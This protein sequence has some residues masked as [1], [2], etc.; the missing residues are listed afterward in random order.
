MLTNYTK[1]AFRNIISDKIYTGIN[2]FGLGLG[3]ACSFII[4]LFVRH[5]LSYDE[6]YVNSERIYRLHYSRIYFNEGISIGPTTS[7][8]AG[9]LLKQDYSEIEEIARLSARPSSLTYN[10]LAFNEEDIHFADNE[11]FELFD[12]QWLVGDASQALTDP[13]SIVL[14]QSLAT[15]YFGSED[16]LGKTVV[17]DNSYLLTV[18][19][20]IEDLPDNTHLKFS[21]LI[22]FDLL[23]TIFL[24]ES[25]FNIDTWRFSGSFTYVML[26]QDQ[27]IENVR[28]QLPDFVSRHVPPI[29][30]SEAYLE[31]IPLT[32]VYMNTVDSSGS[33]QG[34]MVQVLSFSAIA[35]GILLIAIINYI[36]IANA[37]YLRRAREIGVRK[38]AGAD[39]S[40]IIKQ[41][42]IE[43]YVL[44]IMAMIVAVVTMEFLLPVI[45]SIIGIELLVG[46]LSDP[47]LLLSFIALSITL[48]LASGIYPVLV[49]SAY[50]PA[51]VLK[52][53]IIKG[54][55]GKRF[56]NILVIAQFSMAIILIVCISV[57][58]TQMQY[59][60][61]Y[62]LGFTKERVVNFTFPTSEAFD[63][64]S[65]WEAFKTQL[66][67]YPDIEQ[68]AFSRNSPTLIHGN[69]HDYF[70]ARDRPE[71]IELG[72]VGISPSYFDLYE[73][74]FLS[75][76][77][78]SN[79]FTSDKMRRFVS[80]ES[81][82]VKGNAILNESAAREFGWSPSEAIS[83]LLDVGSAGSGIQVQVVG[84]VANTTA[85][86]KDENASL[87]YWNPANYNSRFFDGLASVKIL[88]Y[89]ISQALDHIDATWGTFIPEVPINRWFLEDEIESLYLEEQQQIQLF[90]Y[91]ASIAVLLAC[92]GLFGLATYNTEQRRKEIGVRKV[93]GGS[94]WQI[95]LLLTNDFSKL[96]LTSNLIAWPI[97]F[98]A[99]Q[100]WLESFAFRIDL[101][102]LYFIGSGLIA[103]CIAWVTVG[104]IAT[105]AANTKPVLA[106]RYE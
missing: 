96:V 68:V 8:L 13:S 14:T 94:V 86:L 91:S 77:G 7:S 25:N 16:A 80:D 46:Y 42:L 53:Q 40:E 83:Q 76:R 54:N 27:T 104:S 35:V 43:T 1:M 5:E 85:S 36:K 73:I 39:R 92:L 99:M 56:R 101:S 41:L 22:P 38:T 17:L 30:D 64:D 57:V 70:L 33:T 65:Q 11:L 2:V 62:D 19:G 102:P 34:S 15:R 90:S 98:F 31:L 3:L 47:F 74:E 29:E 72:I 9:P 6:H 105:N 48:G 18:T 75:G 45:N 37:R 28:E 58:F 103:L 79:Q 51:S 20:V 50:K 55:K 87:I 88:E 93:V 4:V 24:A 44:V 84:V 78:I 60:K 95:V 69:P 82:S 81:S 21:A 23:K 32:D 66:L 97:A 106:L 52:G 10:D 71:Q 67:S 26:E 89:S 49:L 12:L 100:G 59:T 63:L 61:K